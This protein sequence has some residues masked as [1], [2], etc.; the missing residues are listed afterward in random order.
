MPINLP[1]EASYI[2]VGENLETDGVLS[3]F[4][5]GTGAL[6]NIFFDFA[7]HLASALASENIAY[8]SGSVVSKK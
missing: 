5:L 1:D 2:A 6:A 4:G 3:D 8:H 7:G